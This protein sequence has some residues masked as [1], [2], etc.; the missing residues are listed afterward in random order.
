MKALNHTPASRRIVRELIVFDN[1]LGDA[2]K[3]YEFSNGWRSWYYRTVTKRSYLKQGKRTQELA[4]SIISIC[5][6]LQRVSVHCCSWAGMSSMSPYIFNGSEHNRHPALRQVLITES[7]SL[8]LC[9]PIGFT[10]LQ[11]LTLL[12][13]RISCSFLEYIPTGLP[14][15]RTFTL[16]D[17][18][19]TP[20]RRSYIYPLLR[21]IR[22]LRVL[23]LVDT[24]VDSPEDQITVAHRDGCPCPESLERLSLVS[25]NYELDDILAAWSQLG[26]FPKTLRELR[27]PMFQS[28]LPTIKLPPTLETLMLFLDPLCYSKYNYTPI[29]EKIRHLLEQN[30][31]TISEPT[32]T[33]VVVVTQTPTS[34]YFFNNWTSPHAMREERLLQEL[35]NEYDVKLSKVDSVG[36]RN[37]DS[38]YTLLSVDLSMCI[39]RTTSGFS[40]K[41]KGDCMFGVYYTVGLHQYM[42]S[43]GD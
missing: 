23:Q 25:S 2:S 40:M 20:W 21:K 22:S 32:F 3:R 31:S 37:Y 14:Q 29:L 24:G 43:H 36:T 34:G 6:C 19:I 5:P 35:C 7:Y 4:R 12:D 9:V 38:E 15:L 27:I 42:V 26:G 39:Q 1:V 18:H 11:T 13:T 28:I 16:I 33:S 10:N 41:A 17:S 30:S 8:S